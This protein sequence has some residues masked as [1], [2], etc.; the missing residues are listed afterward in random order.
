[1]QFEV[2]CSAGA[3]LSFLG[4]RC[5]DAPYVQIQQHLLD[6]GCVCGYAWND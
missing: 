6:E 2:A 5:A 1:M 4:S 3:G